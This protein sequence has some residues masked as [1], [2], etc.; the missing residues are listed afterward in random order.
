MSVKDDLTA[1]AS[2]VV[3]LR[4]SVASLRAHLGDTIDV[5]R[6]RDDVARL[7][8]DLDLVARGA[9]S[10]CGDGPASPARSSTSRT[11]TTTRPSGRTPTTRASATGRA[12]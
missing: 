9:G 10:A 11:R 2:H 12:G 8:A 4:H 6:L 1:T 5:Q 7:A 3:G